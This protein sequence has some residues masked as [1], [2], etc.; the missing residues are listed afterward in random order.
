MALSRSDLLNQIFRL[1]FIIYK[2][3]NSKKNVRFRNTY[4]TYVIHTYVP[5]WLTR[6]SREKIFQ[7]IG[8]R[9][10]KHF[11][12]WRSEFK[13]TIP[14]PNLIINPKFPREITGSKIGYNKITA[15][16]NSTVFYHYNFLIPASIDLDIQFRNLLLNIELILFSKAKF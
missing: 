5:V 6:F 4:W 8:T 14:N 15:N 1:S 12:R 7:K 16:Y 9:I 10:P 3:T 11:T 2:K 13:I